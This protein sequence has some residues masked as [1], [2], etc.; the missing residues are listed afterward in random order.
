[1]PPCPSCASQTRPGF[2]LGCSP[3]THTRTLAC[4]HMA[5]H[6]QSAILIFSTTI[7]YVNQ[8]HSRCHPVVVTDSPCISATGFGMDD[9]LV[10]SGSSSFLAIASRLFC[11]ISDARHIAVARAGFAGVRFP[12]DFPPDNNLK[13]PHGSLNDCSTDLDLTA[14]SALEVYIVS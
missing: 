7:I 6:C 8:L 3:S 2:S 11:R 10:S 5:V 1:M 4:S 14:L 9:W 13:Q 12:R